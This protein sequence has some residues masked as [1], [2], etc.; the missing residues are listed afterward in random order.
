MIRLN[1]LGT[2]TSLST[3]RHTLVYISRHYLLTAVTNRMKSIVM[4]A[5][6]DFVSINETSA[7]APNHQEDQ[8]SYIYDGHDGA[9]HS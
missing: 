5:T 8:A 9:W 1:V 2:S 3:M 6:E 7:L 4:S